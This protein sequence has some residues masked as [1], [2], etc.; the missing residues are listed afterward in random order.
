MLLAWECIIEVELG[1]RAILTR[2]GMRCLCPAAS[3]SLLA[4]A[5]VRSKTDGDSDG[6]MVSAFLHRQKALK[7]LFTYVRTYNELNPERWLGLLDIKDACTYEL[8]HIPAD[9][10]RW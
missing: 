8:R 3:D 7:R 4:P 9:I 1:Q 10:T 2:L 5:A 6:V